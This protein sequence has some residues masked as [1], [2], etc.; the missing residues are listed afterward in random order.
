MLKEFF[1]DLWEKA[2]ESRGIE[3]HDLDDGRTISDK[4]VYFIDDA[5]PTPI[6]LH[7][8]A[9]LVE[10]LKANK[11]A[12]V[13]ED[14][15]VHILD[16][17]NVMLIDDLDDA[18]AKRNAFVVAR[19]L[20]GD[21][22][23]FGTWMDLEGF[24]IEILAKV[25]PGEERDRLLRLISSVTSGPIGTATDDG[26]SQQVTRKVGVT[27]KGSEVVKNPF[28]LSPR[29]TF[30]EVMQPASPLVLRVRDTG[31]EPQVSLF[32]AD[33]GAWKVDAIRLIGDYLKKQF[34][35]N[36][37]DPLSKVAVLS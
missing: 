18:L 37:E 33:G 8:L 29:R 15:M 2:R 13:R 20:V 10:Y 9:G 17:A 12:L 32:E 3:L 28:V 35:D 36:A 7:T 22:F 24:T 27:L 4:P 6:Q 16:H 1:E 26:V 34:G 23:K 14:L 5:T 25:E 19:A 11:D 31:G 30:S 21:Q